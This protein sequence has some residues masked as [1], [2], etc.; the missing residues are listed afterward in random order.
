MSSEAPGT[1]RPGGRT[2]RVR[3]AVLRAAGDA[4]AEHGFDRLDLADVARR[5]GVGKT[6]VYR[7]WGTV[8]GLVA[9]LLADMAEQSLPRTETGT[10]IGDLRANARL[11]RRT[12]TDPR[13]GRLFKAIIAA[14]TCDARTAEALHRFYAARIREWAPCVEQAVARGEL[15]EGTDPHEVIRAVSAPLYYRLLASGDPLDEAA[16]DRAAEAA[17]TAA[18]AGVFVR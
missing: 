8:P 18:K 6:T 2:A 15:P 17:A 9:D 10:L 7:R 12:L 11:V 4:L 1:V 3:E 5:A 13:Q 14:A 16:A